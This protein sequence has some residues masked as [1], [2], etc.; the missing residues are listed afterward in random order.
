M[1]SRLNSLAL[2]LLVGRPG[3]GKTYLSR[4]LAG[5]LDI[6]VVSMERIRR[7]I[8]KK[9]ALLPAE[10][11]T[12]WRVGTMMIEG[13]LSAGISL[14]ADMTAS[15]VDQRNELLRLAHF[16]QA[17]PLVIW[18]QTDPKTAWSRC[19]NRQPARRIDDAF[20]L[21]LTKTTFN[22]LA[23]QL[24]PPRREKAIIVNGRQPAAS[25][26]AAVSRRLIE[27]RLLPAESELAQAV[28]KPGLVNLIAG[29]L[30]PDSRPDPKT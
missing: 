12:V 1:K 6:P 16:F 25:Q 5:Q 8:L 4:H 3:S 27:I 20:S 17:T 28:P 11:S 15:T 10:E 9:P 29:H 14:V 23:R 24:E 22:A 13:Y 19:Q 18:Q 2:F 30:P 26:L 7:T 21:K